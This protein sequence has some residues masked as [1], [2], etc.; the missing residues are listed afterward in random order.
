[1]SL[2]FPTRRLP[3]RAGF[4]GALCAPYNA[5]GGW[6][7]LPKQVDQVVQTGMQPGVVPRVGNSVFGRLFTASAKT[8]NDKPAPHTLL[9]DF[10]RQNWVIQQETFSKL[11]TEIQ[12]LVRDYPSVVSL[13]VQWGVQDAFGHLNN[14]AYFRFAESG[15]W[16]CLVRLGQFMDAEKLKDFMYGTGVGPIVKQVSCKYKQVVEYPDT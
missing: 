5:H 9:D 7:T 8:F 1:M 10:A 6:A 11:P 12:D 13:P 3:L 2:S 15:R 14:V 16:D 4:L